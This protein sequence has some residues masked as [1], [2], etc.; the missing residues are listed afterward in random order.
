METKKTKIIK[1]KI[2]TPEEIEK[3]RLYNREYYNKVRKQ[4]NYSDNK[5][6][7][8]RDKTGST[9]IT[10]CQTPIKITTGNFIVEF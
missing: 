6:T 2:K 10:V 3:I 9:S 4:L 7:K 1:Q 5:Q 8:P